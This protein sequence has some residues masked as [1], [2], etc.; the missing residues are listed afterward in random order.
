MKGPETARK[1]LHST[2][3]GIGITMEG[4]NQN[5]FI[6]EFMLEKAWRLTLDEIQISE[7]IRNFTQRRYQTES[8]LYINEKLITSWV[9]ISVSFYLK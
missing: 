6:Y 3:I 2:M 1:F 5:E 7:F 9:I 4:I 8:M